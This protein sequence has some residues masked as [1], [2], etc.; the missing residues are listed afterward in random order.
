MD[1]HA[2]TAPAQGSLLVGADAIT[3]ASEIATKLANLIQDR[4]LFHQIET[5]KYVMVEGWTTLGALLGVF[6]HVVSCTMKERKVNRVL[7]EITKKYKDKASGQW[8]EYQKKVYIDPEMVEETMKVHKKADN[9]ILREL[10]EVTYTARVQLKNLA[11]QVITEAETICSNMEEGKLL[12]PE[13]SISS[14]AQTRATG[15]AFRLAFSWIMRLAGY[16]ATPWEEVQDFVEKKS[17]PTPGTTGGKDDII[18]TDR[19]GNKIRPAIT[20]VDGEA[21]VQ[22]KLMMLDDLKKKITSD[23]AKQMTIA[24]MKMELDKWTAADIKEIENY[25][26]YAS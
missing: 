8:K 22:K 10:T 16:D 20:Y 24:R 7:V 25:K 14:M 1:E 18:V 2:I 17:T 13:Y 12:N 21:T 15:K 5:N 26:D 9:T 23:M 11:G 6:P 19:D 3:N 4:Q